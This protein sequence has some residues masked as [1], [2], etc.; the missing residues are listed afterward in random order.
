MYLNQYIYI[1]YIY[2]FGIYYLYTNKLPYLPKNYIKNYIRYN[3]E[4]RLTKKK[5]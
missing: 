1:L 4:I 3:M 2:M 5:V